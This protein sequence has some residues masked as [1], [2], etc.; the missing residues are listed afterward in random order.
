MRSRYLIPGLVLGSA[1]G[2]EHHRRTSAERLA[3]AALETILNAIEANDHET[4]QHVRQVARY[5]LILGD[6]AGLRDHVLRSIERIAL[7]HDIGKIHEALFDVI[8]DDSRLTAS[9]RRAIATHPRRGAAVLAPLAPFYPEL[10]VGVL[11]HHERWDGSGYPRGLRG[12]AIPFAARIVS[13]VDSFD[14][15]AN[16][17]HYR[18]AG[19]AEAA[20]MEIARGRGAQF[21]PDLVDL[22]LM[23]PVLARFA[24]QHYANYQRRPPTGSDRRSARAREHL[25]PDVRFRWRSAKPVGGPR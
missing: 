9:E 4:G 6:A 15:I 7:F 1:W 13:I 19:G 11:S 5:A 17:R 20:A 23:P 10:P 24:E 22:L 14:V 12:E 18:R 8:H 25:V 3:A 2:I 21:D 16:G